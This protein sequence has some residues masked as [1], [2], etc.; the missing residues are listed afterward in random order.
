MCDWIA[1]SAKKKYNK[2]KEQKRLPLPQLKYWLIDGY[3]NELLFIWGLKQVKICIVVFIID[4]CFDD[5]NHKSDSNH[6]LQEG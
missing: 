4:G 5:K 1:K 2:V 3:K 6:I